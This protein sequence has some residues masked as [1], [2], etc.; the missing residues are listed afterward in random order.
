MSN[1]LEYKGYCTK[2]EYS[3]EDKVLYGKIEGINDL[4]NFESDNLEDVE[5]EFHNAVDDYLEFC[6]E[7]NKEPNKAYKGSFNVRIDPEMHREIA[8][9]AIK[10][11]TSL[12]EIVEQAI[13]N[14]LQPEKISFQPISYTV[15][16]ETRRAKYSTSQSWFH[17]SL[18]KV[19]N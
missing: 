14:Y 16:A 6:K 7:C 1:I 13:K 5:K 15:Q 2:I 10:K 8:M 19:S 12:N 4:V 3:K 17:S 9:M 18:S 11:N